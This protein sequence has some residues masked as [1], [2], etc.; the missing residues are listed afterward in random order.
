VTPRRAVADHRHGS[1]SAG[2]RQPPGQRQAQPPTSEEESLL[3][4][5]GKAGNKAV[6][7]AIDAPVQRWDTGAAEKANPSGFATLLSKMQGLTP[8]IGRSRLE[9]LAAKTDDARQ[10]SVILGRIPAGEAERCLA[11]MDG[12]TLEKFV[13]LAPGPGPFTKAAN[14]VIQF[15]IDVKAILAAVT[16]ATFQAVLDSIHTAKSAAGL[17]SSKGTEIAMSSVA[18]VTGDGKPDEKAKVKA[19]VEAFDAGNLPGTPHGNRDGDL[20]GIRRAGGYTEHD[21]APPPGVTD[22]GERRLVVHTAKQFVYYTWNHYGKDG[23]VL[24]AFK[25]IR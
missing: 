4:L 20:P 16:P 23:T 7:T 1:S 3:A 9:K 11:V 22:R 6:T 25:R 19:A 17:F 8:T 24:P 18:G 10:L 2:H 13:G 14:E 12:A 5:Q 15:G 21:V